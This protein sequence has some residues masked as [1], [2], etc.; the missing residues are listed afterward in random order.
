MM[1]HT[2]R[3]LSLFLSFFMLV[4][5]LPGA[6][7]LARPW[8]QTLADPAAATSDGFIT[9]V[10]SEQFT[11]GRDSNWFEH[12]VSSFPSMNML[13][14]EDLNQLLKLASYTDQC[15]IIQSAK[16]KWHGSCFGIASTMVLNRLS[17][18]AYLPV[19][20]RLNIGQFQSGAKEYFDL[21]YPKDN[22]ALLSM[23]NYHQ[24]WTSVTAVERVCTKDL[25]V[26][27]YQA[28]DADDF[29]KSFMAQI[30]ADRPCVLNYYN[31]K[32][33]HAVVVIDYFAYN[34]GGKDYLIL[35]MYDEND[36]YPEQDV[37]ESGFSY[38]VF[39]KNE[40]GLY[41]TPYKDIK[42]NPAF[43]LFSRSG[44]DVTET[45]LTCLS[46]FD[47]VK[48]NEHLNIHNPQFIAPIPTGPV[49]EFPNIDTNYENY[50]IQPYSLV[51]G[52]EIFDKNNYGY[53]F[54]EHSDTLPLPV[55]DD[56]VTFYKQ[57]VE[58]SMHYTQSA[59]TDTMP[60]VG[61]EFEL[62]TAGFAGYDVDIG[63]K[64][65]FSVRKTYDTGAGNYAS[66]EGGN[67][68]GARF[69][70]EGRLQSITSKDH[71]PSDL[72]LYLGPQN[73]DS[74]YDMFCLSMNSFTNL[75]IVN[76][77]EHPDDVLLHGD[78]FGNGLSFIFFS[79]AQES[80][81]IDWKTDPN[82]RW[83]KIS[84]EIVDGKIEVSIYS[85]PEAGDEPVPT[86]TPSFDPSPT[87]TPSGDPVP[88]PSGDPTPTPSADPTPA[89]SDDPTPAPTPS[90]V[91]DFPEKPDYITIIDDP[92]TP[93]GSESSGGSLN[94]GAQEVSRNEYPLTN[95]QSELGYIGS[96]DFTFTVDAPFSKYISTS[97]DGVPV[98]R[99]FI[100]VK[101][102][103]TIITIREGFMKTLKAGEHR[104]R[105]QFTDG[106][107]QTTLKLGTSSSPATLSV[108]HVPA[109]GGTVCAGLAML[110][111]SLVSAAFVTGNKRRK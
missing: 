30:D 32:D 111:T 28:K 71:A 14:R 98:E 42:G 15:S 82:D 74:N 109:T 44:E 63:G 10:D 35:K 102:G 59:A 27:N 52:Q 4:A 55:Q 39:V 66:I 25:N 89:P 20:K 88:T 76:D 19:N 110:C 72:Q 96:G 41:D 90:V 56:W 108:P 60:S 99:Q 100:D 29:V 50:C 23:I 95:G 67:L 68:G 18:D 45:I 46:S 61:I 13:K 1:K 69:D 106:F 9:D 104:L 8:E 40:A 103:S 54:K 31:V 49:L 83:L 75:Q 62:K 73:T 86:P 84:S 85:A 2:Q 58:N 5:L 38:L 94:T 6:V 81:L 3:S 79:D 21:R 34:E 97:I 43:K 37:Q 80:K 57:I 17:R 77:A 101:E 47:V 91:P 51:D 26:I 93:G 92:L 64:G 107:M 70:V 53:F 65:D 16:D 87:P 36:R 12:S 78:G 11:I 24:L 33:G 105:V 48:A 22:P 7:A